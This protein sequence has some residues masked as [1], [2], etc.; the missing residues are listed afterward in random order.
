MVNKF[1]CIIIA[2]E[3]SGAR[4]IFNLL[5]Q[6]LKSMTPPDI[7]DNRAILRLESRVFTQKSLGIFEVK[8]LEELCDLNIFSHLKSGGQIYLLLRNPVHR[9]FAAYKKN[10]EDK[11]EHTGFMEAI[12]WDNAPDEVGI[13]S[14]KTGY[15][16]AGKYL[17]TI[18]NL[19]KNSSEHKLQIIRYETLKNSSYQILME[20]KE[21]LELEFKFSSEKIEHNLSR[22]KVAGKRI[23]ILSYFSKS[24]S[25]LE[26][27][28]AKYIYY[29]YFKR[30]IEELESLLD[31]NLS[32]WKFKAKTMQAIKI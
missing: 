22:Q 2:P 16:L 3:Y 12:K 29:T 19:I 6:N 21:S 27:D 23:G 18:K 10:K 24:N 20:I 28:T 8:N 17:Q 13:G 15:I 25:E 32:S 1:D 31:V 30:D 9:A 26:K 7:L 5:Q 14:T 11:I 4:E